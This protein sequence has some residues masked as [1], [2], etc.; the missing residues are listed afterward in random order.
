MAYRTTG[1]WQI[2]VGARLRHLTSSGYI[3]LSITRNPSCLPTCKQ[4]PNKRDKTMTKLEKLLT[5][6]DVAGLLRVKVGTLAVWRC[7]MKYSLAFRKVGRLVRYRAEDVQ[8]FIENN[9]R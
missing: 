5:P 4:R 1:M 9:N 3:H 2:R 7:T 6:A 8:A